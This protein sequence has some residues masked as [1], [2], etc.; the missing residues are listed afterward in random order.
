MTNRDDLSVQR[1]L[2]LGLVLS[3]TAV[4]ITR[5][6][7]IFRD[8]DVTVLQILLLAIFAVLFAWITTSFWIGCL[9]AHAVWR[10]QTKLPLLELPKS[11]A[12]PDTRGARTV[13]LMPIHNENCTQVFARLQAIWESIRSANAAAQFD[14]FI[15]SDSNEHEAC[16]GERREWQRFREINPDARHFYRRRTRNTSHKS[17]NIAE[18]C[19]NW[20]SLYDYMVVLDADSLMNGETLTRLVS[21]MD[22]NPRAALIQV[23]PLL[24]GGRSLFA[25]AQQFASWVYGP[26]YAAG[27]A[28]LQGPDSNYW[29]H[30]AIIRI[31]PFAENCGLPVLPGP[32][33]LGGEIM[34][35]DFV[36][37]ALLRRAGWDLW[38]ATDIGG[39]YEA[40]PPT[41]IEFLKRDR[42]W[43][44]GNLQHVILIF[45]QGLRLPSRLHFVLGAMS[46][47]AS[48]LWL[49]LVVVFAL[50]AIQLD[51]ITAVTYLG[52]YPMLAWPVSH[53]MAFMSL[54]AAAM[55]MLFGP[56]MMALTLLLRDKR[57]LSDYG[58]AWRVILSTTAEC[59][60]S[61][62]LAPIFMLS[63]SWF[64]IN[65]LLGRATCWGRQLRGG[66][67]VGLRQSTRAFAPHT[68]IALAVAAAAWYWT[69]NHFWW[70][71]PLLAGASLAILLC[72]ATSSPALGSLTRGLGLF[73]VKSETAGIPIFDRYEDLAAARLSPPGH[74]TAEAIKVA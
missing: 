74:P 38:L 44:Q 4:A 36:E 40:S 67:G 35:H 50:N 13:L 65:I 37:A 24:I 19:E 29:G 66:K 57:R 64:V 62:L 53:T 42:R 31:R 1:W 59:L 16:E 5:L 22:T 2:L 12:L 43:C 58:G 41:L 71:V 21:L 3:S 55:A 51:R 39:S 7:A 23:A 73:L 48:P 52:R 70:C 61:T 17:G 49:A 11:P 27:L 6:L 54:A 30:N 10:R 69:P 26:I 34:S 60:L 45:A 25:R 63:H 20:G 56:R 33:P 28:K 15:L 9:G 32:P 47:L 68:V 18:F 46:Y 72:W 14:L 8:G